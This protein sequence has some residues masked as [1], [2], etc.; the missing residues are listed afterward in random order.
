MIK[1]FKYQI[2][3]KNKIK[4]TKIIK[5]IKIVIIKLI[6]AKYINKIIIQLK[7]SKNY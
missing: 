6:I 2:N 3:L 5:K 4:I 1:I 7:I